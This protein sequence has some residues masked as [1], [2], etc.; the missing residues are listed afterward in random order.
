MEFF[1]ETTDYRYLLSQ[2]YEAELNSL[3]LD[4]SVL[5]YRRIPLADGK[6]GKCNIHFAHEAISKVRKLGTCCVIA[7]DISSYFESLDHIKLK[8]LWCRMLGVKK[9]PAAHYHV[10]E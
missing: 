1:R 7:L 6:G 2:K 4:T 5:A 10:F 9:L 8:G 3:G